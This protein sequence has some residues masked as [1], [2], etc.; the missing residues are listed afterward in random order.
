MANYRKI[1]VAYDGSASARN[2]LAIASQLAKEGKSWIKVLTIL[3]EYKGDLEL[4]GVSNIKETIEGPGLK[5]LE[6]AREIIDTENINILTDLKL[7][8]PY[9][10]IVQVA[11]EENCD[12]IVMGRKGI[13]HLARELM[14]SVTARVIGHTDKNVLVVPEDA[15]LV[16]N[17][18]LVAVDNSGYSEAAATLAIELAKT[19]SAKLTLVSVVYTIGEVYALT[20]SIAK[21][22]TDAAYANLES[23]RNRAGEMGVEIDTVIKEGE[24]FQAITDLAVETE[25]SL[26]VM[27]SHGRK[28]LSRLLMGSVTERTIGYAPCPVL[29]THE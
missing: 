2:G 22:L 5:L 4:I 6:E 3:P 24:P 28:G 18:I 1:L 19:H 8:K 26:I 12:L 21:N 23:I 17:N 14:G 29:V 16:W 25:A 7:G 9:E 13:N 27:G 15:K 20:P 10:H 11:N